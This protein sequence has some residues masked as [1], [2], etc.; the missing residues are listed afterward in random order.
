M[1]IRSSP[2]F[3][4]GYNKIIAVKEEVPTVENKLVYLNMPSREDELFMLFR[5]RLSSTIQLVYPETRM[6]FI[7]STRGVPKT[8]IK[9][10]DVLIAKSNVVNCFTYTRGCNYTG[11]FLKWFGA[12]V[13][14]HIRSWLRN[15]K[16][17]IPQVP[18]N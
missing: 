10:Q 3:I 15:N 2:P 18:N 16:Q 8:K 13:H 1:K 7:E 9:N 4:E 12:G 11:Q 14:E 17:G 5:R 6:A